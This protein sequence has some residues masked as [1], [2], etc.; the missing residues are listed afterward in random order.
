[1]ADV[2]PAPSLYTGQGFAGQAEL[3]QPLRIHLHQPVQ[4]VDQRSGR[5]PGTDTEP[6]QFSQQQP[7]RGGGIKGRAGGR[8]GVGSGPQF[9]HGSLVLEQREAGHSRPAEFH[10]RAGYPQ[11]L[12]TLSP[13]ARGRVACRIRP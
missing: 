13:T 7:G 1:M 2:H 5:L 8:A 10:P 6:G 3:P 12:V 11:G 9:V 4:A